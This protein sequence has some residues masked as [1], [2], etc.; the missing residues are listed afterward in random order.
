MIDSQER[1]KDN[2]SVLYLNN[3]KIQGAKNN[4]TANQAFELFADFLDSFK[5]ANTKEI[6]GS[7]ANYTENKQV[8]DKLKDK[9][10]ERGSC[11]SLQLLKKTKNIKNRT[12]NRTENKN[13]AKIDAK[14]TNEKNSESKASS[15]QNKGVKPENYKAQMNDLIEKSNKLDRMIE[16]RSKMETVKP[17]QPVKDYEE[18]KPGKVVAQEKVEDVRETLPDPNKLFGNA[19]LKSKIINNDNGGSGIRDSRDTPIGVSNL[20]SNKKLSGPNE[21]EDLLVSES[22]G[23]DM[24][25]QSDAL[26]EF[27]YVESIEND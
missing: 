1:S 8:K 16:E 15:N 20:S 27:D 13:E 19:Q 17:T 22:M 18:K 12:E 21:S 3:K 4:E 10:K 25:V 2:L 5:L 9:F 11:L 24:S 6:F 23:Y 14:Q 7:E 26:E